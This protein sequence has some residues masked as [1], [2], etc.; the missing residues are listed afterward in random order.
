MKLG[1]A[2]TTDAFLFARILL[3]LPPSIL[4]GS[5]QCKQP[6]TPDCTEFFHLVNSELV[7]VGQQPQDA[8]MGLVYH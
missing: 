6:A 5:P 7:G 3:G 8:G 4:V 2:I 1:C